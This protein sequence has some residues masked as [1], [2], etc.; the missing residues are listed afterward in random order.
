MKRGDEKRGRG[1]AVRPDANWWQFSIRPGTRDGKIGTDPRAG[2]VEVNPA[3]S[4][5]RLLSYPGYLRLDRLL[6]AQFPSSLTPDE[7]IFVI[8]HQL[9]ELLFKQTIF[10]LRVIADTFGELLESD[11]ETFAALAGSGDG[12]GGDRPHEAFW[13]PALTAAARVGHSC[14][15]VMPA[16]LTYLAGEET[17]DNQAF[18]K[19]FRANLS[20]ASGFQSAR[21][22]LVQR[23]LGKSPLFSLR[24]F[25]ADTYLQEYL[26]MSAAKIEAE[27]LDP[28]SAGLL[29]VTDPL[30]LREDAP[31]ASPAADS[32]L[33]PV[34]GL[35]DRAHAVLARIAALRGEGQ[36]GRED[37]GPVPLLPA[38]G[39]SLAAMEQA[40]REG[41]QGVL[42]RMKRKN[43]LPLDLS[44]KER[45][46]IE[47]RAAVFGRDWRGAVGRENSRREVFG[48]ACRGARLLSRGPLETVLAALAGADDQLSGGFLLFHRNVVQRRV[49]AVPGTAGGGI[50]FLDFSRTLNERFPALIAFRAARRR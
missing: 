28:E 23:A 46:M 38:D 9:F 6:N 31:T 39:A 29:R 16:V 32:P 37:I 7:R 1:G 4:G 19:G 36:D 47:K 24:L 2:T 15:T 35:D 49:G 12:A 22:R 5:R 43:G 3:V 21:L 27:K 33:F 18:E 11:A 34:A 10:D 44:S 42:E 13:R 8:T 25:P 50:P 48:G 30:I 14:G 17:F 40:F 20:P 26:G 45:E 41:L